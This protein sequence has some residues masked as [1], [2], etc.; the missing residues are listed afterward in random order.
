[1]DLNTSLHR[2]DEAR[3]KERLLYLEEQLAVLFPFRD[4][5]ALL[6]SLAKDRLGYG[7]ALYALQ[8]SIQAMLDIA[9]HLCAKFYL[10]APESSTDAFEILAEHGDIPADFLATAREM[11]RFRNLLVHGCLHTKPG[12]LVFFTFTGSEAL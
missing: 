1:M 8:T 11:V 5:P 10:K 9:F 7:G 6:E 12:A 4:N 2:L 3:V